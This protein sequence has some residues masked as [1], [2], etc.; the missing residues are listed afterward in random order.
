[1]N[2]FKIENKNYTILG[3]DKF[4][5]ISLEYSNTKSVHNQII[6]TLDMLQI[7]Y[8]IVRDGQSK[9]SE[10]VGYMIVDV[11][12]EDVMSFD[13]GESIITE[14]V[15]EELDEQ[16]PDKKISKSM[17]SKKKISKKKTKK[18]TSTK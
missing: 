1:M 9:H 17:T 11:F 5:R 4:S 14:Q 2:P 7:P 18:K 3:V 13:F 12:T 10:A 6:A 16:I 15:R 8:R